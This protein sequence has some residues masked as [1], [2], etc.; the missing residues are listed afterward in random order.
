MLTLKPV[1]MKRSLLNTA[2]ILA[3]LFMGHDV[4]AQ[5]NMSGQIRPRF[6]YRHGFRSLP[7]TDQAPAAFI[8]QRTRL[9]LGYNKASSFKTKIV[10][11]DVRVWGNQPQLVTN[12]GAL[13]VIHEGWA[14][15][16][17][18]KKLSLRFG[19]QE[20]IL[21]DHRIFGNVDWVQQ[22]RSHDAA[23]FFYR[24]STFTAQLGGAYNQDG[25]G[26]AGVV[27]LNGTY[28]SIQYLWLNKTF[29]GFEGSFLFLNHGLQVSKVASDGSVDYYDNYSQLAGIHAEYTK[30]DKWKAHLAAYYQFGVAGD[31]ANSQINAYDISL[32][33]TYNI[34]KKVSAK[35]GA[36]LLSGNSET[37]P[38]SQQRAFNP[39]FGTNHK[40]NGYMDYFYVG[41]HAGSVGLHD[42]YAG[43]KFKND[44]FN[45]GADVHAFMANGDVLDDA[46]FAAD[47][48]VSAANPYLGTEVD[49]TFGFNLSKGVKV[50][51]GYSQ[52]FAT[53]SMEFIKGGDRNATANWGWL[54]LTVNPVFIGG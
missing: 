25:A 33:C 13:T 39:F 16:Q 22:A 19:R 37:S 32:S 18:T 2:M 50:Q 54:M 5:F 36:E 12:D 4:L 27:A 41:N 34:S 42:F 45:L 40:F 3:A 23:V 1:M 15:A 44:K 46:K 8:D 43:S 51:G 28:K 20:I 35:V 7:A 14:E 6:E 9:T 48:T 52:M 10:L 30:S 47:G 24:D 38:S 21:N 11:Q 31:T 49:V 17:M 26:L 29:S 53:E